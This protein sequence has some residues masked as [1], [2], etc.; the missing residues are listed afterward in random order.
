M[1][2]GSQQWLRKRAT[3]PLSEASTHISGFFS[4]CAAAVTLVSEEPV[5][6]RLL[7]LLFSPSRLKRYESS[8]SSPEASASWSSMMLP[9]YSHTKEPA[10]RPSSVRTPHPLPRVL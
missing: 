10:L 5:R 1:R 4:F 2:L 3:E 8:T 9:V 7:R 6:L